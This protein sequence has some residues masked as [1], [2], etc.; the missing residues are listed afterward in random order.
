MQLVTPK[1]TSKK[2]ISE[3][4]SGDRYSKLTD[5]E[6]QVLSMLDSFAPSPGSTS[7][8]CDYDQLIDM[9]N[10]RPAITDTDVVNIIG[11]LQGF[12]ILDCSFARDGDK[13]EIW[14]CPWNYRSKLRHEI[15]TQ[16]IAR[17]NGTTQAA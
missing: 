4:I 10:V 15:N 16:L 12:K 3:T 11:R 8:G 2:I 17:R 9:A 14:V 7:W 6:Q 13:I 5:S 1:P